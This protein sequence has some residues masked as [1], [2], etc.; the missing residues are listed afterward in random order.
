LIIAVVSETLL[1]GN[2]PSSVS[3]LIANGQ[4][5]NDKQRRWW[6][7]LR[8]Y[9]Q[10]ELHPVSIWARGH[11]KGKWL[12]ASQAWKRDWFRNRVGIGTRGWTFITVTTVVLLLFPC[13]MAFI[14]AYYFPRARA[15]CETI[16]YI[17][18]AASQIYLIIMTLFLSGLLQGSPTGKF[19]CNL[20]GP[21]HN[22]LRVPPQPGHQY[23]DSSLDVW[24]G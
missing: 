23:G 22:R 17:V 21:C 19:S 4:P 14:M 11:T 18:Y 6:V 3:V 24:V 13:A 20:L 2:N 16:S 9:Y 1:A 10:G 5:N 15:G 8:G 12:E 7:L